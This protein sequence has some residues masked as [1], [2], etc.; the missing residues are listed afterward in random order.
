[1]RGNN[2]WSIKGKTMPPTLPPVAAMPVA[3]AR[4]AWK[5][6][7]IEAMAGVKIKDVPTPQRIENVTM[8]CQNSIVGLVS[9]QETTQSTEA[10]GGFTSTESGANHASK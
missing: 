8:K 9:K 4:R 10:W 3:F 2:A 6:C 5:K 7:A 1:M